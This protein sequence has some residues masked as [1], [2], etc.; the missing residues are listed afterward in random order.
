MKSLHRKYAAAVAMIW[1]ACLVLGLFAYM[2]VI[3]PQQKARRRIEQQLA[4]DKAAFEL[5]VDAAKP[6]NREKMNRQL[7][8]LT[9]RLDDFTV[10]AS[11]A[12]SLTFD[13][14]RLARDHQLQEFSIRG[15]EA[16]EKT[17][18]S[19]SLVANRIV[20]SFNGSF[21]QFARFLNALER[22]GPVLFVDTL[23]I[24]KP[25]DRSGVQRAEMD[26]SALTRK[27]RAGS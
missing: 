27:P 26:I 7:E 16:H 25:S 22:N 14:S 18:E 15:K 2:L 17:A 5:A 10:P 24:V 9:A 4:K 20:V 1:A 8:Q 23:S 3:S 12:A 6:E 13:I 11:E 19:A 21:T